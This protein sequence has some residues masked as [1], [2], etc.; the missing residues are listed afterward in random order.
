VK[1]NS[2]GSAKNANAR[3]KAWFQGFKVIRP[4]RKSDKLKADDPQEGNQ[5]L[6][7]GVSLSHL[8]KSASDA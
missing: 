6:E 2:A 1:K 8:P 3:T 4:P 5:L 7:A